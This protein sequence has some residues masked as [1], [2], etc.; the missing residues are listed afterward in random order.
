MT[1]ITQQRIT[2][3]GITVIDKRPRPAGTFDLDAI[4]LQAEYGGSARQAADLPHPAVIVSQAFLDGYV[5]TERGN[6]FTIWN[7]Q[8]EQANDPTT[9]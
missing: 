2:G 5:V 3:A 1:T 9:N 8:R 6:I 7:I 4:D